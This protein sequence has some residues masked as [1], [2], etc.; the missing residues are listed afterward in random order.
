MSSKTIFISH[1]DENKDGI[2]DVLKVYSLDFAN[3]ALIGDFRGVEL[4]AIHYTP[5]NPNSV[6]RAAEIA[7]HI[8]VGEEARGMSFDEERGNAFCGWSVEQILEREG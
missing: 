4:A 2:T 6:F 7:M 3:D 8:V 5:G 1:E